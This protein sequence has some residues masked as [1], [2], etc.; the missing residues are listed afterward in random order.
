MNCAD[1]DHVTRTL[2]SYG[3]SLD[4][5]QVLQNAHPPPSEVKRHQHVL[6]CL[7]LLIR[8]TG[9]FVPSFLP[10][11]MVLLTSS[12]R[13]SNP[14]TLK[15]QALHGWSTLVLALVKE[16]PSQLATVVNQ[17]WV[18]GLLCWCSLTIR[19][20]RLYLYAPFAPR[21]KAEM[22]NGQ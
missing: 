21:A 7:A 8:L 6:R 5:R 22:P 2:K 11:M 20:L 10:Q 17:V 3:D 18:S 12:V 16:A 13:A 19:C 4:Q 1:S 9:P 15:L 14:D